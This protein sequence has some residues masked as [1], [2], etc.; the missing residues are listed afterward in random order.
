MKLKKVLLITLLIVLGFLI[1]VYL[2][3]RNGSRENFE[4]EDVKTGAKVNL[5]TRN[6]YLSVCKG[7]CGK[8]CMKN[9]CITPEKN[10]DSV[11]EIFL[12]ETNEV[13]IKADTANWLMICANCCKD[14]CK[15][16]ICADSGN[17]NA[18]FSKFLIVP[19]KEGNKQFLKSSDG[20]YVQLCTECETTCKLLCTKKLEKLEHDNLGL[21]IIVI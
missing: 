3:T 18:D 11:F 6:G 2:D 10:A 7:K 13:S 14:K 19:D 12:H 20:E 17:M 1:I 8:C 5:K 16:I 4:I 21:E 15:N 9:I